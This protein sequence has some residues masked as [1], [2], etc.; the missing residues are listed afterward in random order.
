MKTDPIVP[1]IYMPVQRLLM[2]EVLE[3]ILISGRANFPFD[4]GSFLSFIYFFNLI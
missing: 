2:I 3:F 1:P 4:L